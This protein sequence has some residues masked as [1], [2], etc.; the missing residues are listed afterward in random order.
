MAVAEVES[1]GR[2]DAVGPQT[3]NGDRAYGRYQV[4]GRNIGPWTQEYL[5]TRM[6]I[7]E[8]LAD[9]L[10]Q[11]KLAGMIFTQRIG[12]YQNTHD[13]IAMWFSGQPFAGNIAKDVTGTTVPQYVA[14]VLQINTALA[15][16]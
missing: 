16:E 7:D 5:G 9:H 6:T 12:Q 15:A 1:G 4:M 10:A 13:P 11:D 3:K 14:R 2:Y 8:F